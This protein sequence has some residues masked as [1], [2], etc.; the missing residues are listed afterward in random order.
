VFVYL[1]ADDPRRDDAFA[2]LGGHVVDRLD[3]QR[4]E[5]ALGTNL[6]DALGA[7]PGLRRDHDGVEGRFD[8]DPG[9]LRER[10]DRER[11][12]V[13]ADQRPEFDPQ[14]P[15]AVVVGADQSTFRVF[16]ASSSVVRPTVTSPISKARSN[17]ARWPSWTG[18][19]V[20]PSATSIPGSERPTT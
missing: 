15:L 14:V 5:P 16:G 1:P 11:P 20:P 7:R 2:V 3:P 12:V 6:V 9:R 8:G 13:P 17:R 18:S 19:N 10:P 4:V